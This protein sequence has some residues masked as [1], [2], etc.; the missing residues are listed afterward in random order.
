MKS[1]L[2][3]ALTAVIALTLAGCKTILPNPTSSDSTLVLAPYAA[4][5][6]TKSK[7]AWGFAYILNNDEDL[8]IKINARKANDTFTVTKDLPAG[9]YTITGIKSYPVSGGRTKA[10]GKGDSYQLRRNERVPFETKAGEITILPIIMVLTRETAPDGQRSYQSH[11]FSIL[12]ENELAAL[13]E[14]AETLEGF[15]GWNMKDGHKI[16]AKLAI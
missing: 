15:E 6:A 12:T 14:E 16:Y 3:L 9:E 5:N 11:D 10:V 8:L 13:K 4:D 1:F 7:G 2:T